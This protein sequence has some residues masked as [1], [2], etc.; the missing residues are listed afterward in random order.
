MLQFWFRKCVK[1]IWPCITG[2][3]DGWT[4]YGRNKCFLKYSDT[5]TKKTDC[6]ISEELIDLIEVDIDQI[7]V[8]DI[9]AYG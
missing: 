5:E 6:Y 9:F 2:L 1:S 4:W 7:I 8:T 3:R